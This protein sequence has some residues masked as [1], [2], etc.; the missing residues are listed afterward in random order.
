MKQ[1]QKAGCRFYKLKLGHADVRVI[2]LSITNAPIGALPSIIGST[3]SSELDLK[4]RR[5]VA[6]VA[7]LPPFKKSIAWQRARNSTWSHGN[8]P[9]CRIV[10]RNGENSL[11]LVEDGG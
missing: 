9:E 8:L 3:I 1:S 5:L 10:P 6:G 11:S 7:P 2:A 4:A